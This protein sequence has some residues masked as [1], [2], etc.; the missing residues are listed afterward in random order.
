MDRI[1]LKGAEGAGDAKAASVFFL[2]GASLLCVCD[3]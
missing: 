2:Q 3:E 1:R